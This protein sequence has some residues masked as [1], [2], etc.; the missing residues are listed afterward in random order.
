MLDRRGDRGRAPGQV[1]RGRSRGALAMTLG[2]DPLDQY[3]HLAEVLRRCRDPS[4][5]CRYDPTTSAR[6]SNTASPTWRGWGATAIGSPRTGADRHGLGAELDVRRAVGRAGRSPR[7]W[8]ARRKA[9]TS[10]CSRATTGGSSRYCGWRR[11][12]GSDR[13]ADQ[14]P[15]VG[16][17]D[18]LRA[19]RPA[20]A[21]FVYDAALRA[22]S[23]TRSPAPSHG[24]TRD[25]ADSSRRAALA[26]AT[27]PSPPADA[28]VYDETTR[29]YT[30][31]TTGMPKGVSLN[32]L[33]EV[34]A[35]TT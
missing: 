30:S 14:L 28:T 22:A 8:R 26:S 3:E 34:L 19:R 15:P 25:V 6:C 21:A 27:G 33:V 11:T 7:P 29:L 35:P 5:S 24:A 13:L 10:S 1:S 9:A 32:G 16:G 31:G 23:P 20:P 2:G 17:R 18:R 12:A 4:V